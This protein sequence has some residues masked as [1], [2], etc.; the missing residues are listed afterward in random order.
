MK[1]HSIYISF[2]VPAEVS[3]IYREVL[4]RLV[5]TLAMI[6]GTGGALNRSF[7]VCFSV[8]DSC[9]Y[10]SPQPSDLGRHVHIEA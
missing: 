8:V 1:I 6:R 4:H 3:R 9:T 7:I 10:P 2:D 5:V